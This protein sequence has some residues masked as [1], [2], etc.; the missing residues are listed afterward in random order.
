VGFAHSWPRKPGSESAN[1]V[2]RGYPSPSDPSVWHGLSRLPGRRRR[3]RG[4][5]RRPRRAVRGQGVDLPRAEH[6]GDR[7]ARQ[8]RDT[9]GT[10]DSGGGSGR[11]PARFGVGRTGDEQGR[12]AHVCVSVP[13]PAKHRQRHEHPDRRDRFGLRAQE[14]RP[15]VTARST[16]AGCPRGQASPVARAAENLKVSSQ[17]QRQPNLG[18]AQLK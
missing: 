9:L 15:G 8:Q 1:H 2:G 6:G 13:N 17:C 14:L 4:R 5:S 10:P 7:S 12:G 11:H 18:Q 16:L 3:R